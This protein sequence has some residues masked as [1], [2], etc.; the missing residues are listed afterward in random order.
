MLCLTLAQCLAASILLFF[1]AG[2]PLLVVP[3]P[4][5]MDNHQ[6]ELGEHLARQGVLACAAPSQLAEVLAAWDP[7]TLRPFQSGDAAGIVACIDNFMGK[8]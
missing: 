1:P 6:A 2:K 4:L 8:R 3:N 7:S 5:L